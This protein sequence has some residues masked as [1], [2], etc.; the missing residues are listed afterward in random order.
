[1]ALSPIKYIVNCLGVMDLKRLIIFGIG[2]VLSI[3][4]IIII[5]F[6]NGS[7]QQVSQP[8]LLKEKINENEIEIMDPLETEEPIEPESEDVL[9]EESISFDQVKESV[10]LPERITE[11]FEKTWSFFQAN[12]FHI[13]A[14][15]DSLTQGV[16][17]IT[18]QGGYVGILERTINSERKLVQFENYGKRGNRSVQLLKRIEEEEI[19]S[20]IK[21][22]DMILVTI[23][24]NDIMQVAKENIMDLQL[25]DFIEQRDQYEQNLKE[26]ITKIRELNEDTEVYLI[27]F[28]N[29]FERY[30]TDIK[31][32]DMIVHS[33]NGTTR[34]IANQHK[35]VTYIPTK[36]LFQHSDQNLLAE[37]N[38]HPNYLGYYKIAERVLD[39]ITNEES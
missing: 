26:I 31:E 25:D 27:G 37:D 7:N 14:I 23:G 36:D 22:A 11:V 5:V 39:Y 10:P 20:S 17:D 9:Q 12:S 32:L 15:G 33:Y 4:F 21:K 2:F 24:A 6:I 1:M 13:V 3:F 8:T 30:F 28:Y 35:M 29:P 19:Q 38:F 18:D 16:G 34:Y